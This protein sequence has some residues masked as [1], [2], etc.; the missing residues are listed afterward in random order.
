MIPKSALNG[1]DLRDARV[2]I[3][4]NHT[5]FSSL[6]KYFIQDCFQEFVPFSYSHVVIACKQ[7]FRLRNNIVL[8]SCIV[9]QIADRI[10]EPFTFL[11]CII[12]C[13]S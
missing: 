8:R 11:Y 13:S 9:L 10:F 4:L 12:N 3:Y 2:K 1:F 7:L 5:I 6:V